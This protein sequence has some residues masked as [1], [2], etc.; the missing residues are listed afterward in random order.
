MAAQTKRLLWRLATVII[1]TSAGALPAQEDAP[2]YTLAADYSRAHNGLVLYIL[3]DDVVAYEEYLYDYGPHVARALYS[4]TKS[5]ACAIAVAAVEDGLLDLDELV[6][7]TLPEFKDDPNKA[8]ITVR[9]LL[10]LTSGLDPGS[11]VLWA[12]AEVD[13]YR[14]AM[15]MEAVAAPGERFDYGPSHLFVFGE[16]M[17]RKL[18]PLGENPLDY[19]Y[20]RVFDP[21]GLEVT[22]WMRDIAGNPYLPAGAFLS[23]PEWAKYGTLLKNGGRWEGR[24]ILPAA[25]LRECYHGSTANPAYGLTFWL[26]NPVPRTIITG[27]VMEMVFPNG[28]TQ[29][30]AAG[31][32]DLIAAVGAYNQRMYIIPSHGLVVVRFGWDD[33]TWEDAEFL[34]RLLHGRTA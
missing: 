13:K 2:D 26:N 18:A 19:L 7:N 14:L 32:P 23:A 1:I 29:L 34:A 28:R 20:R 5:F 33:P 15:T 30:Y 21:I 24:S 31:P 17:R 11:E 22:A 10:N 6:S 4:G 3:K 12:T 25:G 9:H 8:K 27:E 16:V